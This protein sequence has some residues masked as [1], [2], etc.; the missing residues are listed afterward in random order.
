MGK[1]TVRDNFLVEVEP[2]GPGDYGCCS[3]SGKQRTE[4]ESEAICQ[5][6]AEDIRRH[7][8]NLP[9]WRGRGVTVT[10]DSHEVCEHCG[11]PW[12]EGDA[13]HNGGCCAEDCKVFYEFEDVA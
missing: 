4:A 7:V 3:I 8:D 1:K 5:E 12:T 9:S 6:I 2:R 10:W 13:P 11:A